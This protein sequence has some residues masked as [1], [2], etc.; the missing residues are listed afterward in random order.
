VAGREWG[1]AVY[2]Q[3]ERLIGE[4]ERLT[5]STNEKAPCAAL[6]C[7]RPASRGRD[8]GDEEE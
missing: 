4:D 2:H 6:R 3:I 8:A 1:R 5:D 7:S